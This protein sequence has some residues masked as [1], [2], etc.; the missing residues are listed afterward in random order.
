MFRVSPKSQKME[1]MRFL[2]PSNNS[3]AK[4]SNNWYGWTTTFERFMKRQM[5]HLS[6]KRSKAD[7]LHA[8]EILPFQLGLE[9]DGL[10]KGVG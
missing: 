9:G 10:Y 8:N 1:K 6:T 4:R 5:V 7:N 2:D 3:Y